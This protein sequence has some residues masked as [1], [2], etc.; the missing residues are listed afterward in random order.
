MI[1]LPPFWVLTPQAKAVADAA[2][3]VIRL[4]LEQ[5]RTFPIT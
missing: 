4:S 5:V 1:N 3:S 2:E